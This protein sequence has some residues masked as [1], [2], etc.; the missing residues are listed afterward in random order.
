MPDPLE[1]AKWIW[2]AEN[3]ATLNAPVGVRWFRRTLMLPADCKVLRAVCHISADNAFELFVNGKKV[4]QGD[5]F[6]SPASLERRVLAPGDECFCGGGDECRRRAE[7]GG[8]DCF[9]ASDFCRG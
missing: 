4:G 6:K 1:G 3:D 2:T 7:S 9:P 8:I 5:N